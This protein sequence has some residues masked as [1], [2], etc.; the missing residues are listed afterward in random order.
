MSKNSRQH[1]ACSGCG[2]HFTTYRNYDYCVNCAINGNRYAQN[3]CPEFGD[4]SGIVK[5][6]KSRARAYLLC[7]LEPKVVQKEAKHA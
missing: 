2:D 5:F 6:P 7:S 1:K 4:G 3:Q